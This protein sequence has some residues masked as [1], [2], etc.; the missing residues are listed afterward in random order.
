M[1]SLIADSVGDNGIVWSG[2]CSE[3]LTLPL[4][5]AAHSQSNQRPR[6][7][8]HNMRLCHLRNKKQWFPLTILQCNYVC[9]PVKTGSLILSR[10]G[11]CVI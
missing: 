1:C 11:D 7:N 5:L 4:M 9:V 2:G 6:V 8:T 3:R 10:H